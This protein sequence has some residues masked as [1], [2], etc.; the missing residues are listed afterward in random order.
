MGVNVAQNKV[1]ATASLSLEQEK[2]QSV[3]EQWLL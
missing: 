3:N 2:L 1:S